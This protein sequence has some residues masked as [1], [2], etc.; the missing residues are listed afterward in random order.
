MVNDHFDSLVIYLIEQTVK[1]IEQDD[2]VKNRCQTLIFKNSGY[3]TQ[4]Q[5]KF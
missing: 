1:L 2:Y 4:F 3:Q 5:H